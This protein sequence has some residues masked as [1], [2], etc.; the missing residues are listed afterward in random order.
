MLG[1]SGILGATRTR[2]DLSYLTT[3]LESNPGGFTPSEDDE[4]FGPRTCV[5]SRADTSAA[6]TTCAQPV[7]M[8]DAGIEPSNP[9]THESNRHRSNHRARSLPPTQLR[10]PVPEPNWAGDCAGAWVP[11]DGC[12]Y[13][14]LACR[15]LWVGARVEAADHEHAHLAG[16]TLLLEDALAPPALKGGDEEEDSACL[17]YTSPSPRDKRQSRMPSSA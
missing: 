3:L 4:A 11:Q 16:C 2:V 17:L 12:Y 8:A 7:K 9:Q 14:P 5:V 1:P 13:V 10:S 6:R 15:G